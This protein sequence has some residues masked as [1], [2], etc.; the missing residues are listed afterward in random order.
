MN[1]PLVEWFKEFREL[2][3]VV[4]AR[5]ADPGGGVG[6]ACEDGE[7]DAAEYNSV[8]SY[9]G[10]VESRWHCVTGLA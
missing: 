6:A 7:T 2:S 1:P 8:S 5:D 9:K 10:V 3:D 4:V